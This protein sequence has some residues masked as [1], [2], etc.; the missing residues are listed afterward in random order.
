MHFSHNVISKGFFLSCGSSS[1]IE[2]NGIKYISDDGFIS[3]GNKSA[4]KETGIHPLLTTLRYFPDKSS[5]KYCY[6]FHVI[7]GAKILL[8]TTYY[9]GGYDGGKDPPVFDQIIDGTKWSTVNTKEDNANGLS[10]YYEII[11]LTQTKMFSFCLARN[12]QTALGSPFI[13]GLE[14]IYLTDS[15]YNATDFSKYALATVSRASFGL[16]GDIIRYPDDEYNRFWQPFTDPNSAVQS[17]SNVISTEFWNIPPVKAFVSSLTTSAV[18]PL[19]I[20]W[21][22]FVLPSSNYYLA[23]YFQ[24]NRV[25]NWRV[26]SVSVNGKPFIN[27]LNVTAKGVTVYAA[28]WPLN[29]QTEIILTPSSDSTIGPIVNAG[30]LFQIFPF[31][32][33]TLTRDATI[34]EDLSRVL[35]NRPSDWNGDPCLPK[36]YSWTGVTCSEFDYYPRIISINL[37]GI[38]M[39]GELPRNLEH[40]TALK[41]IWL[42]GNALTGTI[43]EMGLLK[44]METL[45]L[46]NNQFIG[47]IPQSL[48]QLPR[49]RE[50]FVQNN[51]LTGGIPESLRTR[52]DVIVKI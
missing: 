28:L 19:S 34:M 4:L 49:L 33:R 10:S 27:N 5:R 11:V 32:G 41:T 51:K 14:L 35:Q 12:N 3:V 50:V 31:G 21:P 15:I 13:N 9:Y 22:A 6:V 16:V 36:G 23:L 38:G 7:K 1:D 29:G 26:V 39:S 52:N 47:Q 24:D 20:K 2:E 45:H 44:A 25:N 37:T 48:G 30:E 18:T 46:E 42:G 43:P 8:R 40:L 17:Q